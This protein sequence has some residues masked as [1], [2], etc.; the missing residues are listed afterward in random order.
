[1]RPVFLIYL[2]SFLVCYLISFV[3]AILNNK[4]I[5]EILFPTYCISD[6]TYSIIEYAIPILNCFL[7][8]TILFDLTNKLLKRK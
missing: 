7:A 1:M 3:I 5:K 2:L 6:E 8:V 4:S